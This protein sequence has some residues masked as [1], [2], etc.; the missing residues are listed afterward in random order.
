[1]S[2]D[3]TT[4]YGLL[5]AW[6]R[7]RDTAQGGPLQDLVSVLA[8]Q[9][10]VLEEDLAQSYD[11][12]FIETCAP[13]VV[14]YIGDLLQTT[15]LIDS[16]RI[17]DT[18]TV[19]SLCTDLQG[20]SFQPQIAL[21][22]RADVAK[23][24]YYR[25][26]KTT[27]PM[28]EQL[29]AD[30]TGWA[31]H[32]REFFQTLAWSQA[33][34]NHIRPTSFYA[35]DLR[36]VPDIDRI[37]GP[38]DA[39]PRIV[40]V[41]PPGQ[42]HGW[43]NIPNVGIYLWRLQS[44]ALD[45]T[46]ARP[47]TAA[48]SYCFSA[49]PLGQD[50]PLFARYQ[51][52]IDATIPSAE[53]L[54]PG[55]IR[56]AAF[57]DDLTQYHAAGATAGFTQ[58]YG[59]FGTAP[60]G[61]LPTDTS[62][63]LFLVVDGTPIPPEQIQCMNL[64]TWRQP[65][66]NTVGVDVA[67]GRI[68]LGPS[69]AAASS[70]GVSAFRGFP[71]D[72]GGGGYD[73]Q[74]FLLPPQSESF[75]VTVAQKPGAAQYTTIA[76]A[77]AATAGKGQA[78]ISILDSAS[79]SETLSVTL[80]A[81]ESLAIEAADLTRPHL[82][83]TAPLTVSGPADAVLTLSGLL[84]EGAVTVSGALGRLRVL[85][86]TLVPGLAIGAGGKPASPSPSVVAHGAQPLDLEF[87]FS[88]TGPLD[89][90][91]VEGSRIWLLDSILDGAGGPA[92]GAPGTPPVNGPALWIERSTVF[93]PLFLRQIDSATEALFTGVV[94]TVRRQSGCVRFSFVPDGSTTPRRYRCQPDL[95]IANEIALQ[96]QAG[97]NL[98]AAQLQAIHDQVVSW[99]LPAFTDTRYGQPAY[100][101]LARRCPPQIARGAEDGS[102]MGAYCHLKQPQR[103]S[104]LRQRLQ[105]YL[106]FG[107]A[108]AIVLV[109]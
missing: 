102:E 52:S 24:I 57:Y 3:A 27:L 39:T 80:G 83:L 48:G 21:R 81:G 19:A 31:A 25:R 18:G 26:R 92:I 75:I 60:A 50:A 32:V 20:P 34:R 49:S 62:A 89:V 99:L 73:R 109:T 88:I 65:P 54:L 6:I 68:A 15:P 69:F 2:F 36:S 29:A 30:V 76:A 43:H 51:Q 33:V 86:S 42:T 5:P 104:N 106:P 87:I 12:L 105:E 97:A 98:T 56:P 103:L 61:T 46:A 41:R 64:A 101:Q 45:Q 59:Q 82:H 78:L 84:I 10:A 108:A 93:G 85:H 16:S 9:M 17:A 66:S 96:P 100:A 107:R 63:S 14:P 28:L 11:N 77:I 7:L 40:D 94:T 13:W 47:L 38:F 79:Y 74:A 1:M 95:E 72:L 35:P 70:I 44:T 90:A 91:D 37:D 55:R 4:L 53:P 23:T 8:D 67:L 22:A 58:F 71:A